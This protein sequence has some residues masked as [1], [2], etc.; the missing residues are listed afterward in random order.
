MIEVFEVIWIYDD[1]IFFC[2]YSIDKEFIII[3]ILIIL[4]LVYGR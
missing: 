1:K 2:I 4:G 3:I